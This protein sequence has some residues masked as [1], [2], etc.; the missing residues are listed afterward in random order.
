VTSNRGEKETDEKNLDQEDEGGSES[1][2][3]GDN[4]ED[5]DEWTAARKKREKVWAAIKRNLS[6]ALEFEDDD[7]HTSKDT[8]GSAED[9][10]SA[11]KENTSPGDSPRREGSESPE[12]DPDFVLTSSDGTDADLV[13]TSGKVGLMVSD[14]L[15][16]V[17]SHGAKSMRG[18]VGGVQGE[19]HEAPENGNADAIHEATKAHGGTEAY[20]ANNGVVTGE[21]VKEKREDGADCRQQRMDRRN[22]GLAA[23]AT[24]LLIVT[25]WMMEPK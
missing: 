5:D 6:A 19:E 9:P 1:G 25:I 12:T 16:V 15:S 22:V 20:R 4:G 3:E 24:A 23:S 7:G 18:E 8:D 13:L 2:R 17:E 21:P 11:D 10:G 14:L